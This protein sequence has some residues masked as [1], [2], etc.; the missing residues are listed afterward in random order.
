MFCYT[1]R[2]VGE[3]P[4][5]TYDSV[6]A[7]VAVSP[8]NLAW[9]TLGWGTQ[10]AILQADLV[11]NNIG[12]LVDYAPLVIGG[13]AGVHLNLPSVPINCLSRSMILCPPQGC[14]IPN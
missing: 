3:G 5:C 12:L 9:E 6:D 11:W 4:L 7:G 10:Q 2:A 8:A 13:I 14:M 1:N